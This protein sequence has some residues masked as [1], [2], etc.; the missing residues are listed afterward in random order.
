MCYQ[1]NQIGEGVHGRSP[2][3]SAINDYGHNLLAGTSLVRFGE[4]QLWDVG[5]AELFVAI[6]RG[7]RTRRGKTE[8]KKT[9]KKGAKPS[10]SL[11]PSDPLDDP[12]SLRAVALRRELRAYLKREGRTPREP[13]APGAPVGRNLAMLAD[14]LSLEA[15]DRAILQFLLAVQHSRRLA[16]G[17]SV[18]GTVG[19]GQAMALI[20][21]AIGER[22]ERVTE[23]I[24]WD[25]RLTASGL[26]RVNAGDDELTR[27]VTPRPKLLD[28]M[29]EKRLDRHRLLARFLPE[30]EAPTLAWDDYAHVAAEVATARDLL[31]SA[32]KAG[33]KGINVLLYGPTGTGKTELAGVMAKEIGARL[34]SVGRADENGDAEDAEDR[35]AELRLANRLAARSRSVL[36]FDEA[37]DVF[38]WETQG[39]FGHGGNRRAVAARVSKK[40]FNDLLEQNAVPTVWVTNNVSGIDPAYLRRFAYAVELKRPGARQRAKVLSRHLGKKALPENDVDAIAR[41]FE[42]SPA[43]LGQAVAVARLLAKGGKPERTVIE[44]V[45]E[46]IEKLVRGDRPR[47]AAD[48][49]PEAYRLDVVNASEDLTGLVERLAKIPVTDKP[50]ISL[51]L[52]GPP[53]TGKS[54]LVR[55]LAW[56]MGRRV[57]YRRVSDI[58]SMWVG[59]SEKNIAEAFREAEAD[60]CV[61]LFDEADSFLRDRR[62]AIRSWEVTQ[63]NEFLQQLEMF[64][65]VV[66]C[67]TNLW[68]DLDPAS[69]RRFVFK[70]ELKPLLPEQS[71]TLFTSVFAG[72]LASP[73]R[74]ADVARLREL[75]SLTPGDIA[76]VAR[77]I[78]ATGERLSASRL[79]ELVEA[80]LKAK[81]APAR[82]VGY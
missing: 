62:D 28:V 12:T 3:A 82:S 37:E 81:R 8:K 13:A 6:A 39:V 55:Y 26:V 71:V 33:R 21:A 18:F 10:E 51:C 32:L 53:G 75:V 76:A 46:P 27:K 66:A 54:E 50:G 47:A 36:L 68:Q 11:V 9:A 60:D 42:A 48:F 25:G 49:D 78:R 35:L 65:G 64:R 58:Q 80:E 17:V 31:S 56:R 57:V 15:P 29:L 61:L 34:F 77:R 70:L 69:L 30:A 79:V 72:N 40:W 43:Q 24:R 19:F 45:L 16:G 2:F 38:H 52:Y 23:A 7:E 14:V 4:K 1:C 74:E 44:S 41:R 59:E 63:V 67:T 20:A 5:E 22:V 73:P